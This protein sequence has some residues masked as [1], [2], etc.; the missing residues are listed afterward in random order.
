MGGSK[1]APP[2]GGAATFI[3]M[4][5]RG[6]AASRCKPVWPWRF[7]NS[8]I[9]NPSLHL[10][11]HAAKPKMTDPTEP[12]APFD[13]GPVTFAWASPGQPS[14]GYALAPISRTLIASPT[15]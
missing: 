10:A 8:A 11:F 6:G 3:H 7:R 14:K 9:P 2:N 4:R 12:F 5:V 15:T 1:A 13:E